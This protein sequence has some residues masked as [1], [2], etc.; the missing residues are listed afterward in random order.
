MTDKNAILGTTTLEWHSTE[1]LP[2]MH[3]EEYAE[4]RW[5]QSEPLLLADA[6]GTMAVGYCP[7][8]LRR[9]TR[10]RHSM[11]PKDR[12][13]LQVGPARETSGTEGPAMKDCHKSYRGRR[14]AAGTSLDLG[15]NSN[16]RLDLPSLVL[17]VD[18][19]MLD[20]Q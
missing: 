15:V 20:L 19:P 12:R 9:Q 17:R 3:V 11:R 7:A 4:E 1:D 2:A 13:N 5:M 6:A 14:E 10:V 8:T 16:L 18:A